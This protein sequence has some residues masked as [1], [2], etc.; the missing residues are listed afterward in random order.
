M[1]L[2]KQKTLFHDEK[3]G[4]TIWIEEINPE[5]FD[6]LITDKEFNALYRVAEYNGLKYNVLNNR[7]FDGFFYKSVKEHPE[8][9]VAIRDYISVRR[10]ENN[11]FSA[12][13]NRISTRFGKWK[14]RQKT[15]VI[16][17]WKKITN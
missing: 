14:S 9:L 10:P 17:G 3:E 8:I 15:S 6:I 13:C 12:M 2:S 4:L 7:V 11:S 5:L 16:K 1:L